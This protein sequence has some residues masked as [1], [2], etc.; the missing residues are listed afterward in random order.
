MHIF[1]VLHGDTKNMLNIRYKKYAE[2]R[3]ISD[4]IY[5]RFHTTKY[6]LLTDQCQVKERVEILH[7]KKK[8]A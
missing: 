7:Q 2:Y 3:I 6:S 8:V 1:L 4:K 5:V